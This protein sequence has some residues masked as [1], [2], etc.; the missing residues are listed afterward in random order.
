MKK[1]M[2]ITAHP[3]DLCERA[4]GISALHVLSGDDVYWLTLTSGA[5]THAFGM[6][7][8]TGEDKLANL[9]KVID[10]KRDDL[11][12]AANIIGVQ[13]FEMQNFPENPSMYNDSHYD[14]L[15]DRMRE[16]RPDIVITQHP[17]EQGRF[18]H[19]DAGM[20]V[21]RCVDYVRAP[22]YDSPLAPH[23]VNQV[24]FSYYADHETDVINGAARHSPDVVVDISSVAHLKKAAMSE[25]GKTQ[26]KPGQDWDASMDAFQASID[27]AAGYVNE[28]KYAE[29][30]TRLHA[31]KV[32]LLSTNP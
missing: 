1:I 15:I 24:Y 19:M 31:E 3:Q 17:V 16:Y 8:D 30:F 4:G 9:R 32:T 11:A 20:F 7:P 22:G 21:A 27:G 29:R 26:T 6:F 2:V 10:L 23:K 12:R 25:F 5:V 18:D 14:W 13:R 28:V